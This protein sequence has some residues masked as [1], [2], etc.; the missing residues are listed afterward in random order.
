[1]LCSVEADLSRYERQQEQR[2]AEWRVERQECINDI[3]EVL[4]ACNTAARVQHFGDVTLLILDAAKNSDVVAMAL[5]R[6][7]HQAAERGEKYA[8]DALNE[9]RDHFI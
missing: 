3:T 1:M 6:S 4:A 2:T 9:V 5:A 8:V 7:L